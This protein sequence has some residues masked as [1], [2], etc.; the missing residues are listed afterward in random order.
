LFIDRRGG[1]GD[2][3]QDDAAEHLWIA[4]AFAGS[5]DLYTGNPIS[6]A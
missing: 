3:L 6:A 4:E 1:Q 5:Q 2:I